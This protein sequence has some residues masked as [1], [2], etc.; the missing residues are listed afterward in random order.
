VA[1]LSQEA[2][3]RQ[4][5]TEREHVEKKLQ[6]QARKVD[7]QE[8]MAAEETQH[9]EAR[10]RERCAARTRG[11]IVAHARCGWRRDWLLT[12]FRQEVHQLKDNARKEINKLRE[13]FERNMK[14]LSDKLEQRLA[15]LKADLNL[16][17]KVRA[18]TPPPPPAVCSLW[19]LCVC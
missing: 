15:Q 18:R 17:R 2:K 1:A 7:L 4:D 6:L 11:S 8:R 19:P 12:S 10:H 14:D 3:E 5:A 13:E 16:R 9:T